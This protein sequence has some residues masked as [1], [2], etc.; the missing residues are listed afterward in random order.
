MGGTLISFLLPEISL[1]KTHVF[2]GLQQNNA[3]MLDKSD[4]W[5]EKMVKLFSDKL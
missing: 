1:Y 2:A 4:S 5:T 3:N